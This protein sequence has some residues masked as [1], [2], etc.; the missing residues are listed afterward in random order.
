MAVDN[1]L[2]LRKSGGLCVRQ[3]LAVKFVLPP[4]E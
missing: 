3:Y 2:H 4:L 1:K